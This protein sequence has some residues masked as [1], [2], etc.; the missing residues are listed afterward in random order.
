MKGIIKSNPAPES[1]KS[2]LPI[3]GSGGFKGKLAG[4]NM[5][6]KRKISRG[7]R[8]TGW[9]EHVHEPDISGIHHLYTDQG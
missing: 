6:T 8:E 1:E 4:K 5:F 7:S 9:Q 3:G 2:A